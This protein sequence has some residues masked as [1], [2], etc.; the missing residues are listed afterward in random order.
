MLSTIAMAGAAAA[1]PLMY[2]FQTKLDHY[3]NDVNTT[4]NMRYIVDD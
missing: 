2:N 4:F 1:A 3:R